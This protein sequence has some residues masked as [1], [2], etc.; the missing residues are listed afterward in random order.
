MTQGIFSITFEGRQYILKIELRKNTIQHR[1][2]FQSLKLK[3]FRAFKYSWFYQTRQ[4]SVVL[5]KNNS[6]IW[7][8]A[9]EKIDQ[10]VTLSLKLHTCT[11]IFPHRETESFF[12]NESRGSVIFIIQKSISHH[13]QVP[14]E[15]TEVQL[16]TAI[17][18]SQ[19]TDVY[20]VCYINSCL[21]KK[22]LGTKPFTALVVAFHL[23]FDLEILAARI[24]PKM[25][26]S[27]KVFK[28]I[29]NC[30]YCTVNSQAM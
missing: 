2:I 12:L 17:V 16:G 8:S 29:L 7:L 1:S 23:V 27:L 22:K 15:W 4:N 14:S 5:G 25:T 3:L 6:Q 9:Q 10:F 30:F 18:L 24:T 13:A 11:C 26:K 21:I 28:N 19:W 20:I